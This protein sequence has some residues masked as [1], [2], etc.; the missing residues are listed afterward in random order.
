MVIFNMKC[1]RI[2]SMDKQDAASKS[3]EKRLLWIPFGITATVVGTAI[4]V[5]LY[6]AYTMTKVVRAPFE[7]KPDNLGLKYVDVS[8]PSRDGLM[9]S[10]W[11][12]EASDSSRVIVMIHGANGDRA[13]LGIKML[14]I[15]REMV[16]AGY[17]VL[18]FDLRGH[19]QSEGK[20]ISL[21]YYE[22]RD[23]LGA[24]DYIKQRGMNKIYVIGF[25]MGAATALMT[26]ANCKQI[27]AI[28]A[29]SSF[30]HL[31]DIVKPQFSKRSR[32]P[33]F[34]IPLVLFAAK[35]IH[36]I[37]LSLPKPVDA[38][39]QSTTPPVLIIHGGQDNTVPVEH[40]RIL[41]KACGN[42]NSRLWIVPEAE[43]VGSYR[44]RPEEYICQ[45]VS[46]FGRNLC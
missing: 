24:I 38:I 8:F 18:T 6:A 22:Q 39:R 36:G 45:V 2:D 9:L 34:L 29:D 33:K 25:S 19:G 16:K 1:R 7:K 26:A 32:L 42:P 44:A 30:A 21:G 4:G 40:A 20:H 3:P 35:R 17:N 46:F 28:V 37:D 23:L 43:H 14:D 5:S 12:L 13:D 15:A 11:W 10:G 27:D 31:E 41:A